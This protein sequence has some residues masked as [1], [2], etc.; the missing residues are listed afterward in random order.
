MRAAGLL[1]IG[2]GKFQSHRRRVSQTCQE[3]FDEILRA[4]LMAFVLSLSARALSRKNAMSMARWCGSV[5]LRVPNNGQP[6]LRTMHKA[7]LMKGGE[8]AR[9]AAEYLAQPFCSFVIFRRLMRGR[10]N[11]NDWKIEEI[12]GREVARLRESGRSFILATGH[13]RRDSHIVVYT[14]RVCPGNVLSVFVSPPPKTL[15]PKDIRLTL[16]F[17]E[18]LET[19]K[20]IRPDGELVYVDTSK[21]TMGKLVDHLNRP[22]NQ[23]VIA[24]DAFWKTTGRRAFN[25]SFAGMQSRCF[26]FGS[27]TLSRLSQCPIVGCVTYIRDDGVNVVE[28]GPVI[29]PP[30]LQDEAADQRNADT[31]LDFLEGAIGR[32]P[33]QYALYIGEERRWDNCKQ[34]WENFS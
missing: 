18:L 20:F 6:V 3:V 21:N 24:V 19:V 5:M 34:T 14:R 31:I 4:F 22:G 30:L 16:Q 10:E 26:S 25:R 1:Q 8:A 13:Y 2:L 23:V 27:S 33:S 15:R 29:Q 7:F 12:N 9:N 11:I 28:W 32:R 17:G